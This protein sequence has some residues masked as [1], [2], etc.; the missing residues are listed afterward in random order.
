MVTDIMIIAPIAPDAMTSAM[1]SVTLIMAPALT[2]P[3][4]PAPAAS[5]TV[6]V[7]IPVACA[8]AAGAPPTGTK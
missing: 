5:C 7:P 2:R 4:S 3:V 8:I 6:P 1:L